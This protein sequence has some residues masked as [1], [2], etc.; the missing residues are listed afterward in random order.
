MDA[1]LARL[2]AEI[3][4]LESKLTARYRRVLG[5]SLWREH[6]ALLKAPRD[7]PELERRLLSHRD[8]LAHAVSQAPGLQTRMTALP[9]RLP[10]QWCARRRAELPDA[11]VHFCADARA[12]VPSH[13]SPLAMQLAYFVAAHDRKAQV[14]AA[15]RVALAP[16]FTAQGA[17]WS[18]RS[19]SNRLS[20]DIEFAITTATPIMIPDLACEPNGTWVRAR[21]AIRGQQDRLTGDAAFDAMFFVE[22]ADDDEHGARHWLAEPLRELLAKMTRDAMPSLKVQSGLAQLHFEYMF[23]RQTLELAME[24]LTLLRHTPVPDPLLIRDRR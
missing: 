24:T 4:R 14:L 9:A 22:L 11:V 13:S 16:S 15:G 17:P 3:E 18:I 5:D 20:E 6:H 23:S 8:A 12:S 21:Q 19:Q 10:A 1:R 2:R 7:E